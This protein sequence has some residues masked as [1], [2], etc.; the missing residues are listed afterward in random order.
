[1][2]HPAFRNKDK[3]KKEKMAPRNPSSSTASTTIH[4][5]QEFESAQETYLSSIRESQVA[6][7]SYGKPVAEGSRLS[8]VSQQY[9]VDGNGELDQVEQRMR[10]LDKTGKGHLSN[11]TVYDLV[12]QQMQ[13]QQA[14]MRTKRIAML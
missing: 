6:Y 7:T 4:E 9:D 5:D 3:D 10:D 2:Y 8:K 13:T 1:M 12:L 11:D 14:L